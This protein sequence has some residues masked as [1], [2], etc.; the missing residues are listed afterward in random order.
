MAKTGR[1]G[2]G[3]ELQLIRR[4]SELSELYFQR[5]KERLESDEKKDQ[6]FALQILNGAFVKMIPQNIEQ[7]NFNYNT[8]S[9]LSPEEQDEVRQALLK[10]LPDSRGQE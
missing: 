6:D 2:Y 10:S 8:S 1:T 9:D 3:E 4:Y 5:L 7:S